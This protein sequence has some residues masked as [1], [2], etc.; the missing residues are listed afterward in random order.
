MLVNPL[1]LV[2][3]DYTAGGP[4]DVHAGLLETA[5]MLAIAPERVDVDAMQLIEP[6]DESLEASRWRLGRRGVYWPWTSN[7]TTIAADGVIGDPRGAT[8]RLGHEIE[9]AALSELRR[10]VEDVSSTKR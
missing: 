8:A 9:T 3:R 6:P 1:S 5:V 2:A 7:D 10:L 4:P